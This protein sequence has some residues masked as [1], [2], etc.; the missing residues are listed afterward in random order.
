VLWAWLSQRWHG[1]RA[2]LHV[3]QPATV[4]A[5]HRRGFRLF[6]TWKS[7]HR[8]GRPGVPADVR[9]SIREMS[10]MNPLWDAP[11]IHGELQKLGISVSHH[12]T[13]PS[14][15]KPRT[16]DCWLKRELRCHLSRRTLQGSVA[17]RAG[18]AHARGEA[19]GKPRLD[20]ETV[21]GATHQ[22]EM[23]LRWSTRTEDV[24]EEDHGVT[25][26]G[27]YFDGQNPRRRLRSVAPIPKYH[28]A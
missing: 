27:Q 11:R 19:V 22:Q 8:T 25:R 12:R 23:S 7:R 16:N 18:L 21:R 14:T 2:A 6:W 15:V 28:R 9:T 13:G 17:P 4:L 24:P 10:T 1:W 3:V 20:L 26:V 5:W